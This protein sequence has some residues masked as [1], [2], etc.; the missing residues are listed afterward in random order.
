ME[1]QYFTDSLIYL[2]PNN[3]SKICFSESKLIRAAKNRLKS[4]TH[5][6]KCDSIR[7]VI[8]SFQCNHFQI[9]LAGHPVQLSFG[10]GLFGSIKT[11]KVATVD[12][13][14][15]VS[16]QT[17]SKGKNNMTDLFD[18]IMFKTTFQ[19]LSSLSAKT[20]Q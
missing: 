7:T 3:L 12:G 9:F 17:G 14:K 13:G 4:L 1:Y 6:F 16:V 15:K 20:F 2:T 10:S 11:K 8:F 18:L 5:F 19:C